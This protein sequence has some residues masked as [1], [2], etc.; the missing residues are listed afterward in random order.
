[1]PAP[2]SIPRF[3]CRL[4]LP[5]TLLVLLCNAAPLWAQAALTYENQKTSDPAT[6]SF[7]HSGICTVS[8]GIVWD[9]LFADMVANSLG[10]N[11]NEAAFAFMECFGG[12]MIDELQ[13]KNI[14]N[15]AYTSAARHDQQSWARPEPTGMLESLYNIHYA[16]KAGS[17]APQKQKDAATFAR[18]NDFY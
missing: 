9:N 4:V 2:R 12:G 17:Y 15:A 18:A 7:V 1:M 3:C 8:G 5:A 11:Y 14:A 10:N 6:P 13:A 16:P